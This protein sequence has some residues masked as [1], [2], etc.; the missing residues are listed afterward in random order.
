M[1]HRR[2]LSRCPQTRTGKFLLRR[3]IRQ[4][5]MGSLGIVFSLALVLPS[6]AAEQIRVNYSTLSVE[7]PV[8]ELTD[9][10]KQGRLSP[11]LAAYAQVLSPQQLEQL[12][13]AL[14]DSI[15]LSSQI[16]S[17]FLSTPTGEMMLRRLT[18]II[19]ASSP[20]KDNITVL[21][22]ALILAA[23]DPE[24][25][26]LLGVMHHFPDAGIELDILE[27]MEVFKTITQIVAQNQAAVALVKEHSQTEVA[28]APTPLSPAALA[29]L[30][31][32]GQPGSW[33]WKTVTLSL[34]DTRPIRLQV[35][36]SPRLFPVDVY[37]PQLPTPQPAPVIVISHGLGSGRTV[38]RYLAEHLVSH[39]FVVVVP[40]HP[41]SSISQWKALLEGQ[42][43]EVSQPQEYINRPL[44][45]Q[46]LLD[47]L[48]VRSRQDPIFQGR[49]NLDQVGMIGHSFGGYTALANAGALLSFEQLQ[50]K[51]QEGI[52]NQFNLSLLLQCQANTLK[53]AAYPLADPRIKAI[54]IMNPIISAVFST[55]SL[56]AVQVPVMMF[57]GSADFVAPPLPEQIQ[58]FTQLHSPKYLV[59]MDEG[60]HLSTLGDIPPEEQLFELPEGVSPPV[61]QTARNT[62]KT[63]GLAFFQTHLLGQLPKAHFLQAKA[64]QS[65]SQ[66]AFP[67]MAIDSLSTEDLNSIVPQ[68]SAQQPQ[69]KKQSK[70]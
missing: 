46:F 62:V 7:I 25:L 32:M 54:L 34:Q 6:L 35:S 53:P 51:C 37:L 14:N 30:K 43:N 19:R 8:S 27:G 68:Q 4:R 56:Q 59:L 23:N 40:E 9:Y 10:A 22:S 47:D 13:G 36:G 5:W 28:A 67:I 70:Q 42:A 33:R 64:I 17:R 39:G 26:T 49:L 16:I 21:R 41:G 1:S 2:R 18:R 58:P 12:R 38:Y 52:I 61:S 55:D 20:D 29:E 66:D 3:A 31:A 45:I 60:H 57:S 44:D 50:R 63:L 65:L 11:T 48:T 24:G 15:P 69:S